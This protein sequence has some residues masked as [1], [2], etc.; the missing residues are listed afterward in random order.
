MPRAQAQPWR[1]WSPRL[2]LRS[3]KKRCPY[4][5]YDPLNRHGSL[6][7]APFHRVPKWRLPRRHGKAGRDFRVQRGRCG[8]RSLTVVGSSG[9]SLTMATTPLTS[10][11]TPPHPP[12]ACA[13]AGRVWSHRLGRTVAGWSQ[14]DFQDGDILIAQARPSSPRPHGTPPTAP[15]A[16][17]PQW[18]EASGGEHRR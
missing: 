16:A 7:R 1:L 9:G 14:Q 4:A 2:R 6:M 15:P 11:V 13:H 18:H 10:N 5:F 3:S 8:S 12:R 17:D